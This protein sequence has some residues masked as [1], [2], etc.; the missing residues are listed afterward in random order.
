[1]SAY[2]ICFPLHMTLQGKGLSADVFVT[3]A[4]AV[5]REGVCI[6]PL[7]MPPGQLACWQLYAS[8]SMCASSCKFKL[9]LTAALTASLEVV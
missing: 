7:P 6:G 4:W 2:C 8:S 5:V 3:G 1:M 9:I